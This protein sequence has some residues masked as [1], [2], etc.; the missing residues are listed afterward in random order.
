[1]T[2]SCSLT[3]AAWCHGQGAKH[4]D[5]LFH[6]CSAVQCCA[7]LCATREGEGGG[8]KKVHCRPG[9]GCVTAFLTLR[10]RGLFLSPCCVGQGWALYLVL[11]CCR[12]ADSIIYYRALVTLVINGSVR[13]SVEKGT[14][15]R[16]TD[17]P[18]PNFPFRLSLPSFAPTCSSQ[19]R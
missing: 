8:R 13:A 17:V 2:I 12:P 9:P 16:C 11:Q 3:G 19:R 14:W 18:V 10:F 6:L 15:Q 4:S 5:A 7:V 1:M